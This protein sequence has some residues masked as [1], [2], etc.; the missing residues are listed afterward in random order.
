[1]NGKARGFSLVEAL[2]A[3]AVLGVGLA[4]T[5]HYLGQVFRCSAEARAQTQALALAEA[6]IDRFRSLTNYQP[7]KVGTLTGTRHFHGAQRLYQIQW[8]LHPLP[9]QALCRLS[10][11]IRWVEPD[12]PAGLH[13]ST[14]LSLHEPE[15][16]ARRLR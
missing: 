6:E 15:Q 5:G 8:R 2:V 4:G 16:R 7:L 12:G 1:M 11:R 14:L 9:G 3:L 10:V 13:L